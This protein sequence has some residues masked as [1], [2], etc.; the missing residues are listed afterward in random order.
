MTRVS[1]YYLC[2]AAILLFACI[3]SG[4]SN[5]KEQSLVQGD[6][7]FHSGDYEKAKRDYMNVLRIEPYNSIASARLGQIWFEQGSPWRAGTFL[8]KTV[9]LSPNDSDS[10]LRLAQVYQ[11]LDVINK[12]RV[13][14]L[15]VL[16]QSPAK[17]E[18]LVILTEIAH[19]PEEISQAE[20]AIEKFP[21][22]TAAP[23]HLA[24]ANLALRKK[25][26]G[27]AQAEVK[28]AIVLSPLSPE[29]H[30]ARGFLELLQKNPDGAAE[31]FRIAAELAPAHSPI[32]I[33]YA[34]YLGQTTGPDAAM[35]YLNQLIAKTP[36]FLPAWISLAKIALSRKAYEDA[37]RYLQ[38]VFSY[39][40]DNVEAHLVQSDIW[41]AQ[42]EPT[43]VIVDLLNV[44]KGYPGL[45]EVK[46]RL[47]QAYMQQRNT[48][49]ATEAL[50]GALARNP[51]FIEAILA[52]A[53]LN[54]QTGHATD[55]V[56]PLQELLTKHPKLKA[57]QDLLAEAYRATGHPDDAARISSEPGTPSPQEP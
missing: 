36:D 45:P 27:S 40:P 13:E 47:G 22:K 42:N 5:E 17:G 7:D 21:A 55:A 2:S 26:L 23:Y 20:H 57:A 33:N 50:D 24:K 16:Q 56:G 49:E 12:T 11:S 52:K 48:A 1:H 41:L 14:I 43:K 15:Q 29:A 38:H 19:T 25:D 8:K 3:W 53:Q 54:L 46:Y 44:D 34:R 4:C 32:R 18:A 35:S 9:E 6:Q 39:D 31:G 10:R 30:Q 37:M 28:Q 51:T